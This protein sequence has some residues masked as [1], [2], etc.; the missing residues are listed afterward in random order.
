MYDCKILSTRDWEDSKTLGKKTSQPLGLGGITNIEIGRSQ[1][2]GIGK[3]TLL[4]SGGI[5]S[6][7]DWEES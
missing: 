7:C 4:E 5:T 6:S 1:P 3:E 2:P